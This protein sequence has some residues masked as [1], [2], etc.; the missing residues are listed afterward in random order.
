VRSRR[1]RDSSGAHRWMISYADLVTLL[2][3]CFVVMYAMA[4]GGR[5]TAKSPD[6]I[7][8]TTTPA[9]EV[10]APKVTAPEITPADM[11][12][13]FD[14]LKHD[15]APQIAQGEVQVVMEER[16]IV[17]SLRE[18]TFFPSGKDAIY[19]EALDSISKVADVIRPLPNPVLLEGHT[20]SVPVHNAHFRS[21]WELS[22][23]RSIALLN[24]MA[25]SDG[26]SASRF[27]I[28]GYA[29]NDPVAGNESEPGRAQNRRV[30]VVILRNRQHEKGN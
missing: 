8:E 29:D 22:A 2:L 20:D 21:N 17:I 19:L 9:P 25:E 15:L 1:F 16:G 11:A 13:P 6:R 18:K 7:N 5:A 30:D 28:A 3:A 24:V 26:L 12:L 10:T 14:R 4:P 23:A 27:A